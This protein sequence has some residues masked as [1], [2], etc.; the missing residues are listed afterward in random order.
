MVSV[1]MLLE[2]KRRGSGTITRVSKDDPHTLVIKQGGASACLQFVGQVTAADL[3]DYCEAHLGWLVKGLPFVVDGHRYAAD[4]ATMV[5]LATAIE[6][7]DVGLTAKP[8]IFEWT[9]DLGAKG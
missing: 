8:S 2:E 5:E 1:R 3:L 7:I 6:R 4:Q 9:R